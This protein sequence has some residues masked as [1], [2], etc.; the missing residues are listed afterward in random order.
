MRLL[1]VNP[2]TSTD[3]TARIAATA[4]RA[5]SPDTEIE[6]VTVTWG[7][8]YIVTR[9]EAAIAACATL[10]MLAA[11]AA[12]CDAAVIAAFGDPGLDAARELLSVPVLGVAESAML[13]ASMLARRFSLVSFAAEF[14]PW[15]EDAVERL[16]LRSRLASIRCLQDGFGDIT[17]IQEE[18]ET[19]LLT[20]C[21]EAV[22]LDG[23][24]IIILAGAPLAGLAERLAERVA[25]P[26]LDCV[27]A[28]T[29]Q[30][31]ALA[32]FPPKPGGSRRPRGSASKPVLGVTPELRA[33][34]QAG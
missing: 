19:A 24:D 1:I 15:Y 33:L 31:E 18:K 14:K 29:R 21:R 13:T 10:E 8:P 27:A 16:G 22:E 6:A 9:A 7:V 2:N 26:I 17:R 12:D 11:H 4:R 34:F 3:I 28:A 20:L 25:V 32:A 23:A 30:A 5:A